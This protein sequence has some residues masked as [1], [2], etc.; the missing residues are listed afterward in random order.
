LDSYSIGHAYI[1]APENGMM[2]I[3]IDRAGN[4]YY[5]GNPTTIN[6]TRNNKGNL[7][8]E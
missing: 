1:N 4:V 3:I 5:K 6:L 2:D 7:I 8:K